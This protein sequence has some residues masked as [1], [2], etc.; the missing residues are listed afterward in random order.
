M[1]FGS[2]VTYLSDLMEVLFERIIQNLKD[3]K[4]NGK[5]YQLCYQK[6][7]H[8]DANHSYHLGK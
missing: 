3:F 6:K 5:T 8:A 7:L 2:I 1:K 4:T